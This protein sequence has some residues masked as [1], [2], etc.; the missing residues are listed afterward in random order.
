[1]SRVRDSHAMLLDEFRYERKFVIEGATLSQVEMVVRLNK[2]LFFEEYAPRSINNI[3]FDTPGLDLYQ[4]NVDGLAT[5][6]KVRV[7]WYGSTLG[8]VAKPVLELK[9]KHGLLGA[10]DNVPLPGFVLDEHFTAASAKNLLRTSVK[11]VPF[12][13][14]LDFMEPVLINYYK[15]K[16]FR[17]AD[18]A[19]RVTLDFNLGFFKFHHHH[20][21]FLAHAKA[22]AFIVLEVK[23]PD[24]SNAVAASLSSH[25][26]FRMT[27]MSKYVYG[28]DVLLSVQPP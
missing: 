9:R 28:L 12:R 1:M 5:R 2:G 18:H 14:E 27:K 24:E 15:R 3:Y 13:D 4:Q 20:N 8:P 6:T 11:T 7:R 23:Y 17:S 22:P 21:T 10:K 26:P 19:V 16:Y 25:M